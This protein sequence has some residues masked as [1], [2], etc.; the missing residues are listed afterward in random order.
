MKPTYLELCS[1]E[2]LKKCLHGKTQNANECFNGIIWQRVPKDI[3]V[4]LKTLK[5]G[6]LDALIQFNDGYQ[7]CL[8]V[9]RKFNIIP[10]YFTTKSYKH[11]DE[12]RICDAERHSTPKMKQHRK[13]LRAL[14]KK[15]INVL[16]SKEGSNYAS[17]AF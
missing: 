14:R 7:G 17:G 10:G 3:F 8:N 6:A 1:N 13:I 9:L 16:E 2:L 15:K 4:C 11:L 5:C 12:I